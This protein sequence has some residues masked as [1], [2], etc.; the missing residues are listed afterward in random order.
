MPN[1]IAFLFEK[2]K[3]LPPAGWLGW[4]VLFVYFFLFAFLLW[5]Q[6]RGEQE[7]RRRWRERMKMLGVGTEN[8]PFYLNRYILIIFTGFLSALF[9]LS[10]GVRLPPWGALPPPGIVMAPQGGVIMVFGAFF[11][12]LVA[13]MV[14]NFFTGLLGLFCG[15]FY[16]FWGTHSPF[17]V[18]EFGFLALLFAWMVNQRY[19]TLIYRWLRQPIVAAL[20]L[21]L[22]Y[23]IL[24]VFD[25]ALIGS[26]TVVSR[27]DYALSAALTNSVA[28]AVMFLF[29]GVA[30]QLFRFAFA[31]VWGGQPPWKVAPEELS[32]QR[33][34]ML[35]MVPLAFILIVVLLGSDWIFA[36]RAARQSLI[37]RMK[38]TVDVASAEIPYFLDSGLSLTKQ[39]AL[40]GLADQNAA[41]ISKKLESYM[42][43]VPF[44][45]VLYVVDKDL[46]LVTSF[47]QTIAS[48]DDLQKDEQAGIELALQGI[49]TQVYTLSTVDESQPSEVV[50]LALIPSSN[51]EP[52]GVLGGRVDIQT[53][54]FTRP[55]LESLDTIMEIEGDGYIL[56][57]FD[58]I[59]YHTGGLSVM[60]PYQGEV[61]QQAIIT[62]E[63]SYD[64]TRKLVY[65]KPATGRDWKI[66]LAV[67]AKQAQA[68]TL[69]IA[70]P[71]MGVVLLLIGVAW[72]MIR[73][74][75][76][77]ITGSVKRLHLQAAKIA[78]GDLDTPMVMDRQDEVG[79]LAAS[80]EQMRQSLKSRIGELNLLLKVSQSVAT[81]LDI[82]QAAYPVMEAMVSL[83]AR[84]VRL[85][86]DPEQFPKA[87]GVMQIQNRFGLGKDNEIFGYMDEQV[88]SLTRHQPQIVLTNPAR[89]SVLQ[90]GLGAKP[91]QRL[92][93]LALK[94]EEKNYGVIWMVYDAPVQFSEQEL[95]FMTTLAHQVA[96]AAD[97]A[98]LYLESEIGRKQLASILASTTDPI[99][100]VDDR[101]YVTLANPAA[102]QVFGF[103]ID[104][105]LGKP[106]DDIITIPQLISFFHSNEKDSPPVEFEL[107]NGR[108]FMAMMSPIHMDAHELGQVCVMRDVTY[109]KNLDK[110]KSEFVATV[111][112]DLR[113]PLTLVRG[114]ATMLEMVGEL[115]EQQLSYAHKI[116]TGVERMFKLINNLLDL[117]RIEAN[118]GLEI[119]SLR[120]QEIV[121]RVVNNL[122]PQALQKH[123]EVFVDIDKEA[124]PLV[125]ADST[126]LQQALHNLLENAIKYTPLDGQV[127]VRVSQRE[128]MMVFAVEDTGLGISP[129][130]QPR[131]FEKFYRVARRESLKERGS[132]LGLAI[133]KSIAERHGGKVGL[134]SQLGKGS[135][136]YFMIPVRQSTSVSSSESGGKTRPS[137]TDSIFRE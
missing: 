105:A 66:I 33:Q 27:I 8:L 48:V 41:A 4:L 84:A 15:L 80:F 122:N 91:P 16:A 6:S 132:G 20:V 74:S 18:F 24:Y 96:M 30:A 117:G 43:Y 51:G 9:A 131:V 2:P 100:V 28:V 37:E 47:P 52:W 101:K 62:E 19:R 112:H 65:F 98:R 11:W 44:Y 34:F 64:G 21:I 31:G 68:V 90:F 110:L 94:Y 114:Y 126:L 75:L 87:G 125:E 58:R 83:G 104:A 60:Q 121:E 12:M 36:G 70:L 130:D 17:T 136:F 78:Q 77:P 49:E 135:I 118:V 86:L 88:L 116:V 25:T 14:G 133:V 40:D 89:A 57:E 124:S 106:I 13:G 5:Y 59:V 22:A 102:A 119:E 55:I 137:G 54:S 23:P 29:A 85:V 123:I 71:L 92:V 72:V 69:Q 95:Q 107:E 3:L 32:L 108:V 115:N 134:K 73:T 120:V 99:L 10:F 97:K 67:P 127:W 46:N 128:N 1:L 111:S 39:F 81:S 35:K 61:Y 42:H 113:S 38:S 56:D 103:D 26:A 53:N 63:K 50:F 76:Q 7:E 93:A 109:L 45:S 79:K 129:V 82:H